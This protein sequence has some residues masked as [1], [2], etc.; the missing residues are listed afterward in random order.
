MKL[1]G[2]LVIAFSTYSRIPMPQRTWDRENMR[3]VMCFFPLIGVVLGGLLYGFAR[4]A[5][6]LELW[7]IYYIGGTLLPILVTGGIHMDGFLD[8][9][10]A[11]ASYGEREQKLEILK[12]PHVGAFAMIGCVSYLL[13]YL[14]IFTELSSGYLL[15]FGVIPMWSR[16]F[17]GL[18]VVRF[19][20]AKKSGL[21]A[22]FS[23]EAQKQVV[24]ISMCGYLVAG[25]G[26]L[27]WQLGFM[28]AI[29]CLLVSCGVFWY[30]YRMSM[31]EFGGITGD[32]A[33]YFLQIYELVLLA[34]LVILSKI[35]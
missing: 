26:F 5:W 22:A 25:F 13:L 10:D 7:V 19:P 1:L 30:Y 21:V 32:L 28:Q 31:R 14:G 8:V 27:I 16:A 24:S 23:D 34:T 29:F 12:D 2:S 4:L 3:Y 11:R 6:Q 15:A 35:G 17:S 9:V 18:A 20:K 33:G